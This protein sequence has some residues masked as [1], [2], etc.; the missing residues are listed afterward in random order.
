M[1]NAYCV[2]KSQQF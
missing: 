2:V 1:S